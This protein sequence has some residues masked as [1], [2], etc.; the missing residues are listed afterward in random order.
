MMNVDTITVREQLMELLTGISLSTNQDITFAADLILMGSRIFPRQCEW[1]S[2]HERLPPI[3]KKVL[4]A[5]QAGVTIA[6]LR[7][8]DICP[9]K[10]KMY[11]AGF[12][13]P[14]HTLSSVTHWMPLPDPP[15][16]A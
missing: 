4:V 10:V 14:K 12:K 6:E 13:G 9:G 15:E 1:A 2:V 8:Y 11:W 3:R 7:S 5:Y 16:G